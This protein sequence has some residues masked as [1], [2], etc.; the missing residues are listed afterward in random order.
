MTKEHCH[1]YPLTTS[2]REIWFD[3]KM[4]AE[5]PLY[6]IG[7][8]VHIPGPI[9]PIVFEQ[10]I[11]LLIQKHDALRITLTTEQDALPKQVIMEQLHVTLPV[12]DF[13]KQAHAAALAWMQ[14]RFIEP[15]TLIGQPLFRYDLIKLAED[16]YYCLHQYH[17]LIIDGWGIAL[18]NRSLAEIYTQQLNGQTPELT[19]PSYIDFINSDQ[20]YSASD[21]FER[22]RHYWRAQYPTPHEPLL[23]PRYR[24][25]P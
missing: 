14:K 17:H 12:H 8:Y 7:V 20:H 10:A 11:N 16:N 9:D 5:I 23:N 3:Q 24:I 2:Q 1:L 13:S 15:F 18:L 22:D 4:H 19:S 6:N 25:Q 21:T